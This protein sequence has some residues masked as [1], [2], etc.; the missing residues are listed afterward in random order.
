MALLKVFLVSPVRIP[1]VRSFMTSASVLF[2][3]GM[4]LI[5]LFIQPPKYGWFSVD[6]HSDLNPISLFALSAERS[7]SQCVGGTL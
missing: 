2:M 5:L 1:L 3:M 7:R 4:N 6:V